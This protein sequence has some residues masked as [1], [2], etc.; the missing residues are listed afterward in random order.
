MNER[1]FR[2][3]YAFQLILTISFREMINLE[4]NEHIENM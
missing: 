3:L 4:E 2:K 1:K